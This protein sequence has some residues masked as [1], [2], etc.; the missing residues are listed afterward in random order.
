MRRFLRATSRNPLDH[1]GDEPTLPPRLVAFV[2]IVVVAAFGIV[3]WAN[4]HVVA[5]RE[6]SLRNALATQG[7][8]P[9]KIEW[10]GWCNGVGPRFTWRTAAASGNACPVRDR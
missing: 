5:Q 7:L 8:G 10:V 6:A 4:F 1:T 3:L 9:A 2:V